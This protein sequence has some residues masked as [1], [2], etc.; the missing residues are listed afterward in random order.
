MGKKITQGR[1]KESYQEK[2]TKRAHCQMTNEPKSR[3]LVVFLL[4]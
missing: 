2:K 1:P 4:F 3:R